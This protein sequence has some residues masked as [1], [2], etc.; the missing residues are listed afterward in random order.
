[1]RMTFG[2]DGLKPGVTEEPRELRVERGEVRDVRGARAEE[3]PAERLAA[4][5]GREG[6]CGAAWK[7]RRL[8]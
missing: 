8:A 4:A 6:A 7:T 2:A 1:M 3:E 5:S